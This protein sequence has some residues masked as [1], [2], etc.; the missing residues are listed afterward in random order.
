ML[1]YQAFNLKYNR[2]KLNKLNIIQL[3]DNKYF[4]T[5]LSILISKYLTLTF[6]RTYL[7]SNK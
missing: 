1:R 2:D 3:V 5:H 7:Y 4:N 6:N